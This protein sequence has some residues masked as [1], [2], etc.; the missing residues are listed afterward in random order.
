MTV[1]PAVRPTCSVALS[2][3]RMIRKTN[4]ARRP[5][6]S[7]ALQMHC[8]QILRPPSLSMDRYILDLLRIILSFP[9]FVLLQRLNFGGIFTHLSRH[10]AS[11]DP[12]P[13]NRRSHA[14]KILTRRFESGT[15]QMRAT[16]CVLHS[17]I[18]KKIPLVLLLLFLP[19]YTI[20]FRC[21]LHV[22]YL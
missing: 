11:R 21:D 6:V 19:C 8:G 22:L 12:S 4:P 3:T 7:C 2:G 10:P 5:S 15:N 14:R 20:S 17:S 18:Q 13:L 16:G 9:R 1:W